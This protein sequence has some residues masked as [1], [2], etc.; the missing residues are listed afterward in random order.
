MS[1][2][3]FCSNAC[4][5][6]KKCDDHSK[7]ACT[8]SGDERKINPE[9][10]D[11]K[12]IAKLWKEQNDS[13]NNS[14]GY[15]TCATAVAHALAEC[16]GDINCRNCCNYKTS[17]GDIRS[18]YMN[19]DKSIDRGLYQI[20]NKYYNYPISDYYDRKKNTEM[21]YNISEK[22]T[23][24]Y[25]WMTNRSKH[26][27]RAPYQ[28]KCAMSLAACKSVYT[29][30]KKCVLPGKHSSTSDIRQKIDYASFSLLD[31]KVAYLLFFPWAFIPGFKTHSP[32]GYIL[33]LIILFNIIMV[34]LFIYNLHLCY[35]MSKKK[36]NKN[37]F[38]RLGR[39]FII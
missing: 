8:G 29:N 31:N 37:M 39:I 25:P 7:I 30:P 33:I 14:G 18:G 16:N 27:G 20:N 28:N 34:L 10:I 15:K 4:P 22:G 2:D 24:W 32:P 11:P 21:A 17:W 23:N 3:E 26:G 1:D 5:Y 9:I 19:S 13:D 12:E 35:K 38:C 36:R 6:T